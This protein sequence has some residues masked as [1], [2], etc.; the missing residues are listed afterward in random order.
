VPVFLRNAR[1]AQQ[2]L[3]ADVIAPDRVHF[4]LPDHDQ[5][6]LF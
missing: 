6:S 3:D 2:I 4:D 1:E 5:V